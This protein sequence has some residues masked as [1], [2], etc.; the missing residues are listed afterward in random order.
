MKPYITN[1]TLQELIAFGGLV[2]ASISLGWNIL[3]EIRKQPKAKVTA[4]IAQ[5]IQQGN[6][7]SGKEDYF[8]ISIANV[9]TRPIKITSIG[10]TGYKW[11]WHPFKK[12]NAVILPRQL[13]V[14]LKEGDEHSEYFDYKPS[15]FQKLLTHHIQG[16]HA[17]DAGGN[18]HMMSRRR[19]MK[20]RNQIKKHLNNIKLKGSTRK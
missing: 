5:L 19:M 2:I 18:I 17:V 13:P 14:Y 15:D 7:R 3:N 10:Y 11:W 9:G 8:W 20:F 12:I 16:L 6:P 1:V 4:M